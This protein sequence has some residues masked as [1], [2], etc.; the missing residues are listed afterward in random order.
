MRR[1]L[2][3]KDEDIVLCYAAEL[4]KNKNQQLL[5]KM[6]KLL[7]NDF[8]NV[9]LLLAGMGNPDEMRALSVKC[10]VEKHVHLLGDRDDVPAVYAASDIA[11]ASSLREGLPVNVMEA[12]A[13][14]M[15]VVATKNRGHRELLQGAGILIDPDDTES[16]AAAVKELIENPEDRRELGRRAYERIIEKYSQEVVMKELVTL[17]SS[18]EGLA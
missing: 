12:M 3:L 18:K 13:E 10:G 5:I 8:S 6:M 11:V 15:P 14:E 9:H 4:N 17:Y 16:F 7:L 1:E 2:Q